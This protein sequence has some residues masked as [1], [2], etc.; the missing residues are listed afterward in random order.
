[1]ISL[2]ADNR[3]RVCDLCRRHYVR[4]LYLFGSA[5]REDDFREDDSD[6][7]LYVEF[8]PLEPGKRA[9]SYFGLLEDLQRLFKRP[10]DLVMS[11][12]AR[13]PY[14]RQAVEADREMLYAA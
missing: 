10:V 12:A 7:D 5:R 2:I 8:L 13:N 11:T 9:D 4:R 3:A 6:V 14:F 1:M